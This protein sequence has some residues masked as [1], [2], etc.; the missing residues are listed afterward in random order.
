MLESLFKIIIHH[1]R[2][3]EISADIQVEKDHTIYRGHFPDFALTPG[4]VQME[5]IRQVLGKAFEKEFRLKGSKSIKYP[6]MYRPSEK[7][8]IQAT[9]HYKQEGPLVKVD[10]RLHAGDE[11]FMKFK[12]EFVEGG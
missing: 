10:A 7:P 8:E 11:V 1:Q 5:M 4:V 3:Q 12:G 9:L 2:D 6:S